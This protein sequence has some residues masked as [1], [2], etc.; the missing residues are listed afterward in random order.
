[1]GRPLPAP[2]MS[3]DRFRLAAQAYLAYGIVYWVGGVYLALHGVG[4]S[5][6]GRGR[7]LAS[8]LLGT[9]FLVFIP[10]LLARPRPWFERRVLSRR[11]FARILVLFM[12]VRAYKVG[13]VAFRA[14]T[15]TVAAPWGGEITYRAGATV[16][17]ARRS[18]R[19][20]RLA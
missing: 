14:E 2:H 9:L 7:A 10:M 3:R 15:A 5:G 11:N 17:F 13:Q 1:M 8:I 4:V 19:L 18:A 16:Y 20:R 6:S 12:I